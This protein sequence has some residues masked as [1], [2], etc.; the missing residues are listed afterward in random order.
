MNGYPHK[1]WLKFPRWYHTHAEPEGVPVALFKSADRTHKGF[2]ISFGS[3]VSSS[4]FFNRVSIQLYF[5][6]SI[7]F[8]LFLSSSSFLIPTATHQDRQTRQHYFINAEA[9]KVNAINIIQNKIYNIFSFILFI[10]F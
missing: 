6:F 4:V 8:L 2:K 3:S 9:I 1:R 10:S 7:I 5:L